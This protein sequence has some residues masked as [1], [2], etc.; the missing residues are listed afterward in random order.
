MFQGHH[1]VRNVNYYLR[2]DKVFEWFR[3]KSKYRVQM[4]VIKAM[5]KFHGDLFAKQTRNNK[6][7]KNF[8]FK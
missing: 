2:P 8:I 4:Y 7:Y 6:L 3:N 1:N 5:W